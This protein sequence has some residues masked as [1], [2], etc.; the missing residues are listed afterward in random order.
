MNDAHKSHCLWCSDDFSTGHS[1]LSADDHD[2]QMLCTKVTAISAFH[3]TDSVQLWSKVT[4]LATFTIDTSSVFVKLERWQDLCKKMRRLYIQFRVRLHISRLHIK[5][6]SVL[7]LFLVHVASLLGVFLDAFWLLHQKWQLPAA[8]WEALFSVFGSDLWDFC[9][10]FLVNPGNAVPAHRD[11]L[12]G[13][14]HW[15]I[16]LFYVQTHKVIAMVVSAVCSAG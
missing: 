14:N 5:F 4:F 12:E 8:I 16:T 2:G 9:P 11:T 13:R 15:L 1:A 10:H 3:W 7:S 6:H